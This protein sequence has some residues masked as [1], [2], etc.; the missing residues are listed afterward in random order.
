MDNLTEQPSFSTDVLEEDAFITLYTGV[1]S[2]MRI[3]LR[4][5]ASSVKKEHVCDEL[6]TQLKLPE[7]FVDDICAVVFGER[8]QL[9][10]ELR[11]G[12]QV[13]IFITLFFVS[14]SCTVS[15]RI[16]PY[17][18][19]IILL[20]LLWLS[21]AITAMALEQVWDSAGPADKG[22]NINIIS[23]CLKPSLTVFYC[24]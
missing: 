2:L 8:R 14:L 5:P 23:N 4:T 18:I 12:K 17:I 6:L 19:N 22:I 7:P 24:L 21:G 20:S 3:L 1:L 16:S 11:V 13:N 10:D 15:D 9:T